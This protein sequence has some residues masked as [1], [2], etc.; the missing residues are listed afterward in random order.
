[1]TPLESA[2]SEGFTEIIKCLLNAGADPNVTSFVSTSF[3]T[4]FLCPKSVIDAC[5]KWNTW[6][7]KGM[8]L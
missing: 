3:L 6:T 7:E 1:M 5:L 8:H 2:A 4:L